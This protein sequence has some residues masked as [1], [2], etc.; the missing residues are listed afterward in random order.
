MA[1]TLAHRREARRSDFRQQQ[2]FGSLDAL[3]AVAVIGVIWHHTVRTMPWVPIADRGFLGVDLFFVL[4]G[5][6]I[7]TRLLREQSST[8]S[9]S[10]TGFYYRR[11]LRIFPLYYALVLACLIGGLVWSGPQLQ[12]IAASGPSLLLYLT[13]WVPTTSLLAISWSLATEEQFY[14]VWPPI[15]KLLGLGALPV[16]LGFLAANQLVNF[17]LLFA[18]ARDH[19]EI[20]QVTFTPLCLGVGLAYLLHVERPAIRRVLGARCSALV[21]AA[22]LVVAA[23]WP[24]SSASLVGIQRLVIHLL[25]TALVGALVIREDHVLQPV[26]RHPALV[27]VGTV[28]YGMY[29]MH[30][31]VNHGIVQAAAK[32][33]IVLPRGVL[34]VLVAGFTLAVADLSFRFFE[35]P[36]LSL[37]SCRVRLSRERPHVTVVSV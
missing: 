22:G 13:N 29:L 31:F 18:G 8:G 32:F 7:T 10:L 19:H 35:S 5:F 24:S 14:L 11:L 6:L 2:H 3:R 17:G 25:M 21:V 37:K 12:L 1:I 15:Q 28:S 36:I 30:M 23:S 9:I 4:S 26:V 20:L 16:L 34:F 33:G 27:R